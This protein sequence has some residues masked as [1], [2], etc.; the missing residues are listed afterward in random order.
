MDKEEALAAIRDLA[1]DGQTRQ[2]IA[3]ALQDDGVPRATAY[4]WLSEVLPAPAKPSRVTHALESL[5]DLLQA[6]EERGDPEAI[7]KYASAYIAAEAKAR[8]M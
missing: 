2:Q 6:A 5:F 7:A 8:K 4:R 1:A 3:Q